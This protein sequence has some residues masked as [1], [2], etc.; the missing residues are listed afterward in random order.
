MYAVTETD[1]PEI[2]SYWAELVPLARCGPATCVVG[3]PR[4]DAG[5]L[6]LR[7]G[8]ISLYQLGTLLLYSARLWHALWALL[9][10]CVPSCDFV[11]FPDTD[12]D[13]RWA[14]GKNCMLVISS[15]G[16]LELHILLVK[17]RCGRSTGRCY[18]H[19]H[20]KRNECARTCATE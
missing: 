18:C 6:T 5:N 1:E 19:R 8:K 13:Q 10:I 7:S 15:P 11:V 2:V 9:V 17:G 4:V 12:P 3:W 14:R 20:P 16:H